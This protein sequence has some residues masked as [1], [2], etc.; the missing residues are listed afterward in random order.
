ME[1]PSEN[2][3]KGLGFTQPQRRGAGFTIPE[4]LV[5]VAI[6]V[7]MTGLMLPTFRSGERT[8]AL[9]RVVHKAGQ[10][11][12]RAQEL[13]LRAE[14]YT[15]PNDPAE[16]ISGYGVFFDQNIPASYIIFAEC[17]DN[18]TY[19]TGTDGIVE[20]IQLESDIEISSVSPSAKTSI[21][22]VPPTPLVFTNGN[23]GEDVQISFQ[24]TDG[25][26]TVKTLGINSKG[27]I[28]ID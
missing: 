17:N 11:V 1:T 9:N 4:L 15:C 23:S 6:I 28:D 7:L 25:A 8:L 26:G 22:F 14:I 13:A 20:T 12:R 16:K 24:R 5:V 2:S 18:N 27:V 10:D 21:V 19:D 3:K